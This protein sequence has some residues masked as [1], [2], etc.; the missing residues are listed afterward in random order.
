[1]LWVFA[2]FYSVY[3]KFILSF[4]KKKNYFFKS[5]PVECYDPFL[6]F[7]TNRPYVNNNILGLS[8]LKLVSIIKAQL[9]SSPLKWAKMYYS[10]IM[11]QGKNEIKSNYG[12]AQWKN[13]YPKR[14]Y[15]N[16]HIEICHRS[17]N[18]FSMQSDKF[19]ISSRKL[20]YVSLI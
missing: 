13:R 9:L 5:Q 7:P 12:P 1:M 17:S 11:T 6:F 8:S 3:F 10:P 14:N 18:L 4:L 2:N 20:D 16:S 15:I 19:L